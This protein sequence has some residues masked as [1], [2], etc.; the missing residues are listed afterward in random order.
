MGKNGRKVYLWAA[1]FLLL[2]LHCMGVGISAHAAPKTQKISL[3]C[4]EMSIRAG[5]AASLEV[6]NAKPKGASKK[7]KWRSSDPNVA[8]VAKNGRV[9]A[10]KPGR[11]I[12]TATS[13]SGV[14]AK[15]ACK[16]RVL[17]AAKDKKPTLSSDSVAVQDTDQSQELPHELISLI[18][19]ELVALPGRR[20]LLLLAGQL[21][22]GWVHLCSCQ[23]SPPFYIVEI[24]MDYGT[25]I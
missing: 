7:V 18:L 4:R 12:I 5:R 22:S 2:A 10:K 17:K 11:A 24:V 8:T 25:I 1:A 21:H 23:V 6:V 9:T 16:V 13:K 19:Q 3:S 20:Q 15:A 14:K